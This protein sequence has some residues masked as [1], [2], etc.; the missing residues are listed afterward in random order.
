MAKKTLDEYAAL[1]DTLEVPIEETTDYETFRGYLERELGPKAPITM[2]GWEGMWRGAQAR[3]AYAEIG[4]R[5]ETVVLYKGTIRQYT[6]IRYRDYVTG[7]WV[8]GADISA[9][10]EVLGF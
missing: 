1:V 9:A 8:S 7:R 5:S 4:V 6:T 3:G 10:L 2:E